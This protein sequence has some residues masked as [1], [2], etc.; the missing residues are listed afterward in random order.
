MSYSTKKPQIG[1]LR[2]KIVIQE[3]STITNE[4]GFPESTWTTIINAYSKIE[5]THGSRF[6]GADTTD[7]KKTS[8]FTIRYNK[9]LKTKY[10]AKLRILHNSRAFFVQYLNNIDERNEFYEIVAETVSDNVSS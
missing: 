6:F 1:E 2:E 7:V 5:N 10:E 3:Y 8:K 9:E 4:N